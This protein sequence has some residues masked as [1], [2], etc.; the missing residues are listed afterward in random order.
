MVGGMVEQW[1]R[2]IGR[3][4]CGGGERGRRG[5]GDG[6]TALLLLALVRARWRRVSVSGKE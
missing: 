6:G 1:V 2:G 4:H 3:W 5:F